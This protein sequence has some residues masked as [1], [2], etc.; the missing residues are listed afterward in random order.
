MTLRNGIE[1]VD[2][3]YM[4]AGMICVKEVGGYRII[5]LRNPNDITTFTI[6]LGTSFVVPLKYGDDSRW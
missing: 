5:D 4:V 1:I 2:S 3:P 6:P